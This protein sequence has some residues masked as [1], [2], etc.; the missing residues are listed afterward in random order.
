[1]PEPQPQALT[2]SQ[3]LP[4]LRMVRPEAGAYAANLGASR[5]LFNV[6]LNDRADGTLY[7]D[8]H[9]GETRTSSLWIRN[10]A[11][12]SKA[13]LSDGQNK[14]KA[15]RYVMQLG[16]NVSTW[17]SET[18][19]RLSLGIM[20]G[21]AHQHSTTRNTLTGNEAKGSINGYSVGIYSTWY[22]NPTDKSGLYVDSWLQY[23]WFNNEVKGNGLAPET[24]KSRGLSS[25]VETGYSWQ[26]LTLPSSL[27]I[28]NSFWLQPRAQ[29]LWTGIKPESHTERNGTRVEAIE[30]EAVETKLGVRA[31]LRSK[32][33]QELR[34]SRKFEPYVEANWIHRT[35]DNGLKMDGDKSWVAGGRNVGEFKA[36]IEGR[37][38]DGLSVN[39][40]LA[41]QIGGKSHRDTEGM[42]SIKYNF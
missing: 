4:S 39:L 33:T 3:P 14:T 15:N 34:I 29:I 5:T 9:T 28:E 18:A 24:Y 23:G 10:E 38:K 2:K 7:T 11:G 22:Q 35:E 12:R 25:S 19:G 13:A 26:V 27:D 8:P 41:Q 30:S 42:L 20:G 40:S 6:S 37:L 32:S 17:E 16:G 31:F 1:Q 21:Y 36:G